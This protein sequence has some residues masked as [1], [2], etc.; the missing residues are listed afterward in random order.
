MYDFYGNVAVSYLSN[1]KKMFQKVKKRKETFWS[2]IILQAFTT[3][4]KEIIMSSSFPAEKNVSLFD[5][6][7]FPFIFK[8]KKIYIYQDKY[9]K[10]RLVL[11]KSWV[12]EKS[13]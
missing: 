5:L 11:K 10:Q 4:F 1:I 6:I 2:Y 3:N 8:H 13:Y 12:E 7:W 9:D